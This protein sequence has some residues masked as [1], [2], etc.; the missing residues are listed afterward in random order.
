MWAFWVKETVYKLST[1]PER[2]MGHWADFSHGHAIVVNHHTHSIH[3]SVPLW[4]E[5]HLLYQPNGVRV[6]AIAVSTH[7]I[8]PWSREGIEQFQVH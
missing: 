3:D 6:T 2:V 5:A 1:E 4:P 7:I 8:L